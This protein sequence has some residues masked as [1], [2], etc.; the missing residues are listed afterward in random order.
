MTRDRVAL[1]EGAVFVWEARNG[2]GGSSLAD[3]GKL[4]DVQSGDAGKMAATIH[5]TVGRKHERKDGKMG[6]GR[7]RKQR[8]AHHRRMSS[9]IM[10]SGAMPGERLQPYNMRQKDKANEKMGGSGTVR[11]RG[12]RLR[13]RAVSPV[14][15]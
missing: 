1:L 13:A 9:K 5:V 3:D 12:Q 10:R 2:R 6:K 14:D 4:H 7:S 15:Q 11:S 8:G